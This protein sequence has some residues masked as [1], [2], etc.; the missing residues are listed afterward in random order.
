MSFSLDKRIELELRE[1]AGNH[2]CCD[3]EAKNPQWASVSFGVFMC[4][5]CS[6]R[7]RALGV[8]ISFVRSVS[9][10]SWNEKQ[11]QKMRV[12]GNDQCIQFLK[13]YGVPKNTPIPQKY[14]TP[15]AA[16]YRDRIDAAANGRPLPTE[17]PASASTGNMSGTGSTHSSASS[18]NSGVAQG[19]DPLPGESEAAYVARQRI[20]QE[21]ARERMRQ[22][23]G[24][25]NG[26][27]SGSGSAMAGIGSDP[28]Y[29]P[30]AT[31]GS[32]RGGGTDINEIGANAFSFVSSWADTISKTTQ[33]LV[34]EATASN[35]NSN[36]SSSSNSQHGGGSSSTRNGGQ[37]AADP[38]AAI[39]TGAVGLWKQATEVTSD[40]VNIITKPE[41]EEDARFPR[42]QGW[43][44]PAP[45]AGVGTGIAE[46]AKSG[47]NSSNNNSNLSM[48]QN[49]SSGQLQ[50]PSGDSSNGSWDNL[51]DLD[52][53]SPSTRRQTTA[54]SS[55]YAGC[56]GIAAQDR[57]HSSRQAHVGLSVQQPSSTSVPPPA[58]RNTSSSSSLN[59]GGNNSNNS[60]KGSA[61]P[62][63]DDF[64]ATFGI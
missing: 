20:L 29:R 57:T 31:G 15:A 52:D 49:S 25:S 10:D 13:K 45:A 60:K 12:G 30:G 17:L 11:I 47:R 43:T 46:G 18:L 24:A 9:M 2:V 16:L 6:G 38:W 62:S 55:G 36:A 3:C 19:T 64:F 39:T 22:K 61:T 32:G 44:A 51:A 4:L 28:S 21:E 63:S 14:N 7:H 56:P 5:E 50:R 59:N 33:Q 27:R 48:S 35:N 34:Q 42:P 54:V 41:E 1:I 23:F 53:S 37:E 26:L 8:H 58:V 40:L